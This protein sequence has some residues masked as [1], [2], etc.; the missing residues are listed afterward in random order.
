MASIKTLLQDVEVV[1]KSPVEI[2]VN[3][4]T[5]DSRHIW[6]GSAFV[7]IDGIADNGLNYVHDAIDL[8][9]A[10]IISK[11][12]AK[13]D[14]LLTGINTPL[15]KVK[16]DR[17]ALSRIAANLH[18]RPSEKLTVVGITGTN[19]KTTTGC[20]IDAILKD[21]GLR[22]G[23]IGTLGVSAPGLEARTGLTTPDCVELQRTLALF[24]DGGLTHSVIE[25]SSHALELERVADIDF[26][27]A[28]FT[29][30]SRDHL[31]FHKNMDDYFKAKSKL[32]SSLSKE[33]LAVINGDDPKS[34]ELI[35]MTPA[36]TFTYGFDGY[37]DIKF[38]EWGMSID[39]ITGTIECDGETIQISSPL[40]GSYNLHNI[41]AAVA[42]A[43]ALSIPA[44]SI[45]VG[46][47]S[48]HSVPGRVEQIKSHNGAT[49][50]VDYA[51][52][53]D[54]YQKLFSSLSVLLP[55]GQRLGVVFGCGG[56]KDRDKRPLMAAAAES[57]AERLFIAPDNPRS[58]P[59]DAINK[60][61]ATGFTKAQH[62]FYNDRVAAIRDAVAWLEPD[63]IL[64][65]VG[66]GQEDCQIIG[67][68]RTQYSEVETVK[69]IVKE[70]AG[71]EN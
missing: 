28:I 47:S 18:G 53:P 13:A 62:T 27:L 68:E 59:I 24:A 33:S 34:S 32:F 6:P 23:L 30:F 35:G 4:V 16:N 43:K 21:A 17:K 71:D 5:A 11:G 14:D 61:I 1:E 41:L 26:D 19:G 38:K 57:F 65:I 2:P 55:H 20:L 8:G 50:I 54:A 46:I 67:T 69:Q 66:K 42:A 40:I 37:V 51:H 49:I 70:L 64:A 48:L 63:D 44:D 9:A 36:R 52:T 45:A 25:V 56:D 29:N 3:A 12:G 15:V 10:L 22:S 39:G 60:D 7:A 31:D 58:E